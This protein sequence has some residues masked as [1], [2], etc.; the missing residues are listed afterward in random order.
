MRRARQARLGWAM[1]LAIGLLFAPASSAE[2]GPS[3]EK[4]TVAVVD[5]SADVKANVEIARDV[6]RAMKK[7]DGYEV[8]DTHVAL[9]AG[10]EVEAQNNIRTAQAFHKTGV[11]ALEAGDPDDAYDQLDSAAAMMERDFAV[12]R[13]PSEYRRLLMN[14]GVAMVRGGEVDA[15]Q[16]TFQRAIT[17]R[18]K[19]DTIPLT[20]AESAV[21]AKAQ[22]AISAL[23]LGAVVI[24]TTPEHAEVYVNGRYRG[25]SP[26]TIA[27]LPVGEHLV[28]VYK[29]G[30]ARHTAR[31]KAS[32]EELNVQNID[33]NAAR[34][35]IQYK[36]LVKRLGTEVGEL[37]ADNR[38]G[39]AGVKSVGALFYSELAIVVHTE[40]E[41]T[42][43]VVDLTLFHVPTQRLLN[44]LTSPLDWSVRN[45]KA[46]AKLVNELLNI[47][48]VV[49][50]GGATAP[51]VVDDGGSIWTEW[52]L[53]T[54]VGVAVAGG[55]TAGV[56]LSMPDD[57]APA[58]V[59]GT[60]AVKF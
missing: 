46:V 32:A 21:F 7:H 54:A 50:M 8:K 4:R 12:L 25:I 23:P 20:D 28:S 3:E 14:L 55:V 1:T 49:A 35:Q 17:F 16:A 48:F 59:G 41:S 15:A 6:L 57:P 22:D 52:W 38:Q 43:K 44:R 24:E 53:W 13:D 58:P 45:K 27:G 40:G 29:A 34:R 5:I 47:D 42:D 26:A 33:M 56:I 11:A 60:L 19:E 2:Q 37:S 9:N 30:H 18:A 51:V 31:I 36:K 39:G 10:A